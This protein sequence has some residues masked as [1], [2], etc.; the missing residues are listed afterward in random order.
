MKLWYSR[1][2]PVQTLFDHFCEGKLKRDRTEYWKS[3]DLW[4]EY[5]IAF[6]SAIRERYAGTGVFS[7]EII[8]KAKK[9]PAS[10]LM[11]ATVL[12]IFQETVLDDILGYLR[13]KEK[14][15]GEAVSH[16][17]PTASAFADLVKNSLKQLTPAFFEGWTVATGQEAAYA[18]TPSLRQGCESRPDSPYKE[19]VGV[20]LRLSRHH[21]DESLLL[22]NLRVA[23]VPAALLFLRVLLEFP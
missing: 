20:K 8:D 15:E 12:K 10:K 23:V 9:E 6:W 2:K 17:I 22:L 18:R 14:K 7:S 5:F 19:G 11:T 1:K 13:N 3:E 4:F 16:S 21:E